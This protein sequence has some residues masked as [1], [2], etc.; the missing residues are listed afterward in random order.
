MYIWLTSIVGN[1]VTDPVQSDVTK[2]RR[3]DSPMM[4]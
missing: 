4:E 2:F 3:Y 1:F